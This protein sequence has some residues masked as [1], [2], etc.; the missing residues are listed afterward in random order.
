MTD[1]T[2]AGRTALVTGCRTGI[3]RAI[4]LSLAAAGADVIGVSSRLSQDAEELRK[5]IEA[6][7]RRFQA[8]DADLGTRDEIYRLI[9]RLRAAGQSVDILINNAGI[10]RRAPVLSHPDEDWDAVLSVNLDAPFLLARELAKGMADR[11]WG[12]IVFV[13]SLLSFQGG[14]TVPGYAA[15]KGA[16]KQLTMAL[17]NE[18]AASGVCVNAI[19]PGYIATAATR[20]LREDPGRSAAILGRIPMGRWGEPEDI[21]GAAVFLAS[22]AAAYVS[23]TTLVVDGGWLGR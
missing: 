18:L 10:I 2:V 9:D 13:A 15:S 20:A 16:I 14:I 4:A 8:Y 23:G 5:S 6:Y 19:A 22:P 1:F 17:S 12:R 3:G 21:A 11:G 7:G